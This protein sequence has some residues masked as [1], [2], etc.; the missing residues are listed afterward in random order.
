M[1]GF[2]SSI[3]L[4]KEKEK[5]ILLEEEQMLISECLSNS[6]EAE[7]QK[8][9]QM[10]IDD[11]AANDYFKKYIQLKKYLKKTET[12]FIDME[13]ANLKAIRQVYS[14]LTNEQ[15]MRIIRKFI[16]ILRTSTRILMLS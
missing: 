15:K 8:F 4:K 16:F 11:L 13:Q 1:F 3:F 14:M 6:I 2:N 7:Q 9:N 10:K 12:K 5:K